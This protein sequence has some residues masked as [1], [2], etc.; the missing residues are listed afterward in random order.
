[1]DR[2]SPQQIAVYAAAVI[3]I[4]V[5]GARYLASHSSD[6]GEQTMRADARPVRVKRSQA[7]VY[8]YVTGAVRRPGVYKLPPWARLEAAVRRAGGATSG[9]DLRAV[10]LAAK[11]ADGQQVVVPTLA[12]DGVV[13]GAAGDATTEPLSLNTAT[14]EQLDTLDGVGPVTVE[15]II[16]WRAQHGGFSS[17][18]DL[19]QIDGIGPKT[20][21]ALKDKV[22]M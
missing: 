12:A 6:G 18:D 17:I 14:P 7:G 10:N 8:V 3:A 11:V 9:A 19:K 4:A 5:I 2:P 21:A 1:M 22:R 20:F 13:A 15:K 16:E